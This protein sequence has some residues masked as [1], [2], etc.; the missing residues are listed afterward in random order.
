METVIGSAAVITGDIQTSEDL[1]VE[2]KVLGNIISSVEIYIAS[3]GSVEG[4]VEAGSATV[5]GNIQGNLT[6]QGR[7]SF[8]PDSQ[9]KG[10]LTTK[11][12][13]IAEGAIINGQ[14]TV[15]S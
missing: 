10:N 12:L 2:G 9:L 14:C 7:T 1:R 4:D 6:S 3:S 15:T 8:E 5:A 11:S 13:V